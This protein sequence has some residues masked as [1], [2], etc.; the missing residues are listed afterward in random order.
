MSTWLQAVASTARTNTAIYCTWRNIVRRQQNRD[1]SGIT[2][3]ENKK[4]KMSKNGLSEDTQPTIRSPAWWRRGIELRNPA[5]E[6]CMTREGLPPRLDKT[7]A[8][9]H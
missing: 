7:V 2:G 9:S 1:L 6:T 5:S 8:P 3:T 4:Q